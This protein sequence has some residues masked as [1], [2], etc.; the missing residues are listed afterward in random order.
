[1]RATVPEVISA[2]TEAEDQ[3]EVDSGD[4]AGFIGLRVARNVS[5]DNVCANVVVREDHFLS[6]ADSCEG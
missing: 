5:E 6:L 2:R 1:M 4:A 3:Q